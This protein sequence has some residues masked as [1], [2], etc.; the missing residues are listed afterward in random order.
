[1]PP[2]RSSPDKSGTQ[3]GATR[4]KWALLVSLLGAAF[5]VQSSERLRQDFNQRSPWPFVIG[6]LIGTALFVL[7]VWWLVQQVLDRYS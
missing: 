1:M 5:G 7:G 6:G 4:S 3:P 2:N